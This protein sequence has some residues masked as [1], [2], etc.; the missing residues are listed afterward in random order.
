VLKAWNLVKGKLLQAHVNIGMALFSTALILLALIITATLR[1]LSCI[2]PS[3]DKSRIVAE[4][5]LVEGEQLRKERRA[6]ARRIAIEKYEG[7]LVYWRS[8]G[9]WHEEAATLRKIAEV[10]NSL[11]ERQK[12]LDY[13]YQA[14]SIYQKVNDHREEGEILNDIGHVHLYS[15]KTQKALEYCNKALNISREADNRKGEAQALSNLGEVYYFFGNMQQSLDYFH[16]ALSLWRNL[17]DRQGQARALMYFGYIYSDLS[18]TQNALDSLS[19]ALTIWQILN[20]QREQALTL[21]ALGR[22]HSRSGEKQEALKLFTQAIQF[23]QQVDDQIGQASALNG[24]GYIYDELGESQSALEYYKQALRRYQG[25]GLRK[26]EAGQ[27]I[28]IGEMYFSL[29]NKQEA[30]SYYEQA[31]SIVRALADQRL[32]P[33]LLRYIGMIHESSGRKTIALRYYDQALLL[34]RAGKDRRQEAYTLNNIGQVYAQLGKS[35]KAFGYYNQALSLNQAARDR[36]AESLTLYNIAHVERDRGNLSA[37]RSRTEDSLKVVE[38]LRTKVASQELRTSYFASIHQRYEFYTDLLW[39]S[40]KKSPT[41]GFDVAALEAN[42]RARARSM[43]EMLT[44]TRANIR[45]GISRELR[46][47]ERSMQQTLNDKADRQARLLS[48]KHTEE[49]A[50]D[51]AKEIQDLTT[52]YDQVKA[53]IRAESPHY[54]ALTQPKPSSLKEIQQLLDDDTLLLEYALGGERSYLWAVTRA[55]LKSYELPNRAE[56]EKVARPVYELLAPSQPAS[57]QPGEQREAEYWRQ[58]SALSKMLLKPIADQLGNKRLL[59]V[60]DG[61]LQYIPLAAL[62]IP[63]KGR[64]RDKG[65]RAI[66]NP[67]SQ[68]PNPQSVPLMVEHEIINLPSASTLVV[69]RRELAGR[70]PAPKAVAALADPVFEADDMRVLAATGKVKGAPD[71]QAHNQAPA[72]FPLPLARLR[73]MTRDGGFGRLPATL[74]EARAIEE[75]T[76]ESERLIAKGF[77]ASR[78][79]ATDPALSRYRI[80]HFATHGILDRDNPELSAIVLSLVDRQGRPQDGYL[81]LH[82]IYNLNLPAELVVLSAC[83]TG[84]G[85]EFKG[86]GLIGLTRGFMYAGAA[87]VMASLWKVEDEPTAKLM[88]HFYRH[89]LKDGLPPAAALRQ[90]QIALWRDSEWRAPYFWA[91]FVI[92]GEWR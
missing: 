66:R 84:L 45:Q 48:G 83:D 50:A 57:D 21:I 82:D 29:G 3:R 24:I 8:A 53:Q 62:P 20:D 34:N 86:E 4:K 15:G 90:A 9:E 42:E 17:D 87:R 81:R 28:K 92:Q 85:K 14:L 60:A 54:A 41:N 69:L 11:G 35:W 36:F 12:A 79:R 59:I 23:A 51:L 64:G 46:E 6:E 43:L 88:R 67:Q 65:A 25:A 52:R 77:D 5:A 72:N 76:I 38:S 37:A 58:A 80:I 13:Y 74:N 7:A 26:G 27:L 44:E 89:M 91:A 73:D 75:V 78:A 63:E 40:H 68:R 49:E 56:I 55:G 70:R 33:P 71:K 31:L 2:A 61:V 1:S 18:E 30:L 19:H 39:R 22:V 10:Y 32:E 16:Q 47:R